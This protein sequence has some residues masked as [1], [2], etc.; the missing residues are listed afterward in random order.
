MAKRWRYRPHDP[1]R[2]EHLRRSLQIPAFL[3]QLL[4]CRGLH[5][6]ETASSF[7]DPRLTELRD[8]L[9]LPGMEQAVETISRAIADGRR[10]TVYGDY[11]VDG[12]SG[13]SLLCECLQLLGADCGFY[14]PHRIEE[15]YG[16][17][18]A[19]IASLAKQGTQLIV[20]VD[21]GVTSVASSRLARELGID[22][23]ITD[24]HTFGEILPDVEAIVHPRLPGHAYPFG[25]LSGAGV[26]MKLAWGLCQR[27]A[28]SQRVPEKMKQFLLRAVA[29][30]SLGTVA[31]VVPLVD[32]NRVLVHS[33]LAE[34][35][36]RPPL[37]LA[38]MM[39]LCKLDQK[40]T[41]ESEDVAFTLAPRMNATGRLGQAQL[42]VELLLTESTTRALAL[43]EYIEELNNSRQ[44]LERSIYLAANKQATA[45][46][47]PETDAA[48]VLAGLGW[49]PGVI[50]IVAG[51]LADKF[52]RPVVL[53]ALDDVGVKPGVGSG[54]SVAGF[55][56]HRALSMSSEHLLSFGGHAAAAGLR[57]EEENVEGFRA[58]LCEYA[59]GELTGEQ[60]E[61]ELWIDAEVPLGALTLAS[62]EQLDRLA[63]FGQA[64]HRPMLCASDVRLGQP[65]KRM[66]GG[67]R[68]L[69]LEV[70]QDTVRMRGVAFGAGDWA[71]ELAGRQEPLHLAFR[72]TINDFRGRRR[73][74]LQVADWQSADT[75]IEAHTD[76]EPTRKMA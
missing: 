9:E 72:P 42:A 62:I 51:R 55:D 3:A 53:I 71:D 67:G 28:G 47:D 20:T 65:P 33:G 60:R 41:L 54:R 32:E 6:P 23:V 26:A 29:L 61:A 22:V 44:S 10:I 35:K 16:L 36:R 19:A 64:N 30:A 48:L 59:A 21:C 57:I 1:A 37:G 43:A 17:N 73:V 70:V 66:G 11:D 5:D 31:D 24:H 2:V 69:S 40:R 52:H 68:H 39:Q 58:A 75:A 7:L 27:A 12:I 13:T 49:H 46:F 34:L 50:G 56:L 38:T 4:V 18:D 8:P 45:E 25:E 15:G 76:A 14:V 74:E 63:P